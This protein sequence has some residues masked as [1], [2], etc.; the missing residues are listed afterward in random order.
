M[1]ADIQAGKL[2]FQ[3]VT[4]EFGTAYA[5]FTFQVTDNGGTANGGIDTDQSPNSITIDVSPVNDAPAG[6]DAT[7]STSE[8]DAYSFAVAD[9]G[10]SDVDA[11]DSLG[12]VRIA[13]LPSNGALTLD[14]VAVAAGDV[15][16]AAGI[17]AGL[18][19]FTPDFDEFGSPYGSFTFEVRD[20]DG[21]FD[22]SANTITIDVIQDIIEGTSGADVL[23]GTAGEDSIYGYAGNDSIDGGAGAD[24]MVGGAGDD[25][26]TV[27]DSGDV[28]TEALDEGLDW[29]YSSVSHTLAPHVERLTLTG[30]D[31]IDATG[32]GLGNRLIGND[33][34]N[35]LSGG[36]G[37]DG[38][39]G[40]LGA[41]TMIGGTGNDIYVVD[42]AGDVVTEIASQGNDRVYSSISYTLGGNVEHLTLTGPGSIDGTGNAVANKLDG[43]SAD[44]RLR[45]EGRNDVIDGGGGADNLHG[46]TGHDRL[47][48]GTGADNFY[49]DTALSGW[50]NVDTITDFSSADDTI[51]L[52]L[53]V[54]TGLADGTLAVGAFHLGTA[55]ADADHRIIYDSATGKIF[56]DAD[57]DAAG[58]QVLF[59]Q[60]TAGTALTNVDFVAFG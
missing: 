46:G 22:P 6:A 14:G 17:A 51:Q 37:S 9:F 55:A 31:A 19:V 53:A 41:D 57:G 44:N 59:A 50:T 3:P 25:F 27:D 28:V 21:A 43:N 48:G 52:D 35:L 60:V 2:V 29:V 54:F 36:A 34:A 20:S 5:S 1:A 15:V 8:G 40:G 18:L 47:T 30:T 13:T 10:F 39:N 4:D 24:T 32:N 42:D 49:F 7:I 11:G 58:A 12:A 56:Y 23:T 38:I 45:G 16:A 33:A 26:Y